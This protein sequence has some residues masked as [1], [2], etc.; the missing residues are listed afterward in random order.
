ME[1]ASP[2]V[3][4][5]VALEGTGSDQGVELT[6]DA[7][8]AYGEPRCHLRGRSGLDRAEAEEAVLREA[9]ADAVEGMLGEAGQAKDG[10]DGKRERK[11]FES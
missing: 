6:G 11:L 7:L 5:D 8:P 9:H 3:R 4:V 10:T 2:V 1:Q